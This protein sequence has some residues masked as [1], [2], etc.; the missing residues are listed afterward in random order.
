MLRTRSVYNCTEVVLRLHRDFTEFLRVS[1]ELAL[2][3]TSVYQAC[4]F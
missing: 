3:P 1:T 2:V 4:S